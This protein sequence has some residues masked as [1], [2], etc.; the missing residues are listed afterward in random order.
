MLRQH[1]VAILKYTTGNFWLLIVP[2]VRGLFA[3]GFDFYNWIQG[4]YLD[5]IVIAAIVALAAIRW[6]FTQFEF[7][8]EGIA[9]STGVLV[10]SKFLVPYKAISCASAKNSIWLRPLKAVTVT[11]DSDAPVVSGRRNFSDVTL[12]VKLNNYTQLYNK[13]P[14]EFMKTKITYEASGKNLVFFSFVFS[15]T[16]TGVIFIG[17]FFIQGSRLVGADTERQFLSAVN[18]VTEKMQA[19]VD[20]VTPLSATVT[21]IIAAGWLISFASNLIRH[22]NFKISRRGKNIIVQNGLFS[23]WKYYVNISKVNYADLRQNFLMKISKVMSV[24]VSCTGY[25]K[26]RNELPVFV[27]VTTR[28]RVL[29]TMQMM[30]PDFTLSNIYLRPHRK[31]LLSYVLPPLLIVLSIFS[32]ALFFL[33]FFSQWQRLIKFFVVMV[34]IPAVYLLIVKIA[35]FMS[36]GA[37][38]GEAVLT[39]RYCRFF[40]FHTVIVPK[41]RVAYTKISQNPFQRIRKRCDLVVFIRGERVTRH[42]LKNLP[43]AETEGFLQKM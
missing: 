29:S 13:I 19:V 20:G 10:K 30:L 39:L 27:P 17:T 1:K 9:I 4:A 38:A 43:F 21:L 41:S 28:K 7:T 42:R 31:A 23:K 8:D 3:M 2:L 36:T 12:T 16:L 22:T 25:G 6:Y 40:H 14:Y 15:S 37:G 24:H 34:E 32:A 35:A 18:E 5:I 11:I 26:R 33:H